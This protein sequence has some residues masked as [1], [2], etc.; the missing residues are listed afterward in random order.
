MREVSGS[1]THVIGTILAD[2]GYNSEANISAEGPDRLVALGKR[3][4]QARAAAE[5][6][7]D[8]PPPPGVSPREANAHRLRTPDGRQL[9]KRRGATVEPGIGNLKKI[10]DCFSRRGLAS[11]ESELHLA[12]MAFNLLKVHKAA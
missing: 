12:A 9:Y 1:S 8:G 10:L 3:R 6:P 5:E 7:T 4:D 11:A 2:A